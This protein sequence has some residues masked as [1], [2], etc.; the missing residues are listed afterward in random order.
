MKVTN[1]KNLV[2]FSKAYSAL[3]KNLQKEVRKKIK[4]K[5]FLHTDYQFDFRKAG[6]VGIREYEAVQITE[7]FEQYGIDAVTGLQIQGFSG[8]QKQGFP[9]NE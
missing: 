1:S 2:N 8:L 7:V 4:K 9:L 3:P 6:R 5:C